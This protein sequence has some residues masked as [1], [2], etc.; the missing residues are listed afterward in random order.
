M[1]YR[2]AIRDMLRKAMLS[3]SRHD[4]RDV[5]VPRADNQPA[6]RKYGRSNKKGHG[7]GRALL[8]GS[9]AQFNE[10]SPGISRVGG[11]CALR[12]VGLRRI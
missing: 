6:I 8:L 5:R 4:W 1:K 10:A 3:R 9:Y 7:R 2:E 11:I 12:R